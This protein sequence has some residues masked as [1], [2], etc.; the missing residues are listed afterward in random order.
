MADEKLPQDKKP[1]P[2]QSAPQSAPASPP[3]K[4]DPKATA[5]PREIMENDQNDKRRK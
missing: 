2:A 3:K 1:Q 5:K 4:V